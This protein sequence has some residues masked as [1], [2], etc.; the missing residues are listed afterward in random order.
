[1]NSFAESYLNMEA[2]EEDFC[3]IWAD[4]L[5]IYKNVHLFV[6]KK[7]PSDYFYNRLNLCNAEISCEGLRK[8]ELKF[9]R[10]NMDC[11]VYVH[12]KNAHSQMKLVRAG[13]SWID[14]MDVLTLAREPNLDSKHKDT[15]DV[16]VIRAKHADIPSWATIFCESF[17]IQDMQ[18]EIKQRIERSF[19]KLI[20][21][22]SSA[23]SGHSAPQ[24]AGCCALFVN[25]GIIGLYCLGTIPKFRGRGVARK[26]VANGFQH[27][28]KY[29]LDYLFLQTFESQDLSAFYSKFGFKLAYKKRVF[30]KKYQTGFTL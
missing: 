3:S 28:S 9:F 27:T 17:E 22:I 2:N 23:C 18:A 10:N 24:I 26:L 6:N 5:R 20:L 8:A 16:S 14:T 30:E 7:M 19:D 4:R 25:H 11:Y 21:L 1:M 15:T 12:E 29:D 13:F